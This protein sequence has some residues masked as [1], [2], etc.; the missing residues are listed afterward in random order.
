MEIISS[1][2]SGIYLAVIVALTYVLIKS[3]IED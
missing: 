3:I 1:I 2:I